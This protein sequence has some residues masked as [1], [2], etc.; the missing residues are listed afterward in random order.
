MH[1]GWLIRLGLVAVVALTTS[2]TTTPASVL[3]ATPAPARLR[4]SLRSAAGLE[5]FL[6]EPA[7]VSPEAELPMIVFLHGRG[8]RP[9]VPDSSIYGLETPVRLILPRGP[10][11]FRSGYAWM[12]VSARD[13]ESPALL[14]SLEQRVQ[15]LSQALVEWRRLHPTRGRPIVAGFSQGGILAMTLAL[16]EPYAV[17]RAI[18]IAAWVPPRLVPEARDPY[19]PRAPVTVLHGGSDPLIDPRRTEALV[20]RLQELGYPVTFEEFPGIR[21]RM[22][23]GMHRRY[24]ALIRQAIDEIPSRDGSAGMT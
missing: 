12:P 22:S 16:R 20:R 9:H 7:H 18:P 15:M 8:D 5:Y 23:L 21:H 1:R 13:G 2:I 6:V 17:S 4:V 11:R 19:A 10:E 24:R 3:E 14:T